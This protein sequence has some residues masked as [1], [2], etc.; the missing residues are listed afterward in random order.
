MTHVPIKNKRNHE[1]KNFRKLYDGDGL[2]DV[3]GTA[4]KTAFGFIKD[5]SETIKNVGQAAGSVGYAIKNINDARKSS[6]ELTRAKEES[7]QA[8]LKTLNIMEQIKERKKEKEKASVSPPVNPTINTVENTKTEDPE[9]NRFL[10]QI[11]SGKGLKR[12]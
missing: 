9:L 2:F 7:N 10:N 4:A 5:N 6:E 8:V 11:K 1:L 12:F 3:I